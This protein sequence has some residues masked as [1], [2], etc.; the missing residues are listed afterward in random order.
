M[1]IGL[2]DIKCYAKITQMK[3]QGWTH[4]TNGITFNAKPA[5]SFD[6]SQIS[7]AN[8]GKQYFYKAKSAPVG[9]K[10][11]CNGS[12]PCVKD[13]TGT[14]NSKAECETATACDSITPPVTT[15]Y[16]VC[17]GPTYSNG[18]KDSGAPN[19]NG[20]I[21][22]VQGCI[23][24][25]QDSKFGP[26]TEKALKLKTGKTTFSDDDV[27]TICSGSPNQDN[28]NQGGKIMTPEKQ[29]EFF[30][31]LIDTGRIND[32]YIQELKPNSDL[33]AKDGS[34]YRYCYIKKFECTRN[35]QGKITAIG[36][37]TPISG[38]ADVVYSQENLFVILFPD[39][40]YGYME[41]RGEIITN[42]SYTW[43]PG[44]AS[45]SNVFLESKRRR[46]LSEQKI[47]FAPILGSSWNFSPSNTTSQSSSNT[48]NQSSSNTTNQSSSNTSVSSNFNEVEET[49]KVMGPI[50]E[51]ALKLIDEWDD[52][53][54]KKLA[55]NPAKGKIN[56][57]IDNARTQIQGKNPK[58]FCSPETKA[59]LAKAK[60]DLAKIVQ[61]E[62]ALEI[63]WNGKKTINTLK[64]IIDNGEHKINI[65]GF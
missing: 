57:E 64:Y 61:L 45:A 6:K 19:P 9:D 31:K 29:K 17:P 35:E 58:D 56:T 55:I 54:S 28:Q 20:P 2:N 18:C 36:N 38:K 52:S 44:D 7:C 47:E 26:K 53:N 16:S 3:A 48:T 22:K 46:K 63:Y 42:P 41:K 4:T 27:S 1:A 39:L 62:H 60:E 37:G 5:A 30:D 13:S 51:K 23:G 21:Y 14:Y 25:S 33:A 8:K 11:K 32:G 43:S 65:Y 15:T 34:I 50:K 40:L 24:A 10:W 12:G 49:E 59:E